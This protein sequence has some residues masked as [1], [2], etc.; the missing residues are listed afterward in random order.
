MLFLLGLILGGIVGVLFDRIWL[1]YERLTRVDIHGYWYEEY[2]DQGIY[3]VIKNVGNT[4]IPDYDLWIAS[5][6]FRYQISKTEQRPLLPRQR[7]EHQINEKFFKMFSISLGNYADNFQHPE[8]PERIRN[9]KSP[10]DAVFRMVMKDSE[11]V[12]FKSHE[13]GNAFFD[14][15]FEYTPGFVI[16]DELAFKYL[17]KDDPKPF[18]EFL[19]TLWN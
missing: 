19:D 16:V 6:G 9:R 17:D 11:E 14:L 12:L 13:I 7:R 1:R 18:R 3:L 5:C 15:F 4:E 10:T 8:L 2:N